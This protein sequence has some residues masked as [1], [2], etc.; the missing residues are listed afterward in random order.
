MLLASSAVVVGMMGAPAY[1]GAASG[2]ETINKSHQEVLIYDQVDEGVDVLEPSEETVLDADTHTFINLSTE[3]A[4][5]ISDLSAFKHLI[6]ADW[7][8]KA[9]GPVVKVIGVDAQGHGKQVC[10]AF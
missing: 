4:C 2:T 5:T 10:G 7:G 1:A 3:R 9:D 6:V 8:N